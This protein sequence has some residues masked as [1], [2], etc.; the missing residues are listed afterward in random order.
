MA[1]II[2]VEPY[3]EPLQE[4]IISLDKIIQRKVQR[5]RR[6]A[7]RMLKRFPLFAA[8]FMQDEFPDYHADMLFEDAKRRTKKRKSMRKK[9][10]PMKQQGRYDMM[11]EALTN[12]RIYKDAK[13]LVKAQE[14]RGRMYKRWKVSYRLNG[15][16]VDWDFP[17]ETSYRK[18][19]QLAALKFK[20]WE[21]LKIKIDEV[22]KF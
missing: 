14:L 15:E 18:I 22:F 13:Y 3:K 12:Y 1:N 21:E 19:K 7:K 17:S 10:S 2:L 16:I 8:E 11:Q 9:K 6:V 4:G 20:S 5:R